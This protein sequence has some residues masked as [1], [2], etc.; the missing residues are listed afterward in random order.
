MLYGVPAPLLSAVHEWDAC[1]LAR[2]LNRRMVGYDREAHSSS[3]DSFSFSSSR[4]LFHKD[5]LGGL[6]SG[7]PRSPL[8]C[9]AYLVLLT[10]RRRSRRR[11][12]ERSS[13]A[14]ELN[15]ERPWQRPP[16]LRSLSLSLRIEDQR[17]RARSLPPLPP[18]TPSLDG[19]AVTVTRRERVEL[20]KRGFGQSFLISSLYSACSAHQGSFGFDSIPWRDLSSTTQVN[21][22]CSLFRS[23]ATATFVLRSR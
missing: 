6:G 11:E 7:L 19:T 4:C 22:L 5:G 8:L 3:S 18:N 20:T 17:R 2:P 10:E 1:S 13:R 9:L 23:P 16:E 21:V 15:R 14:G 12:R